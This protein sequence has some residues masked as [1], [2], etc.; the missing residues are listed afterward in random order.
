[1]LYNTQIMSSGE[2]TI[3]IWDVESRQTVLQ[4]RNQESLRGVWSLCFSPDGTKVATG[5]WVPDNYIYHVGHKD[6]RC[7]P[8]IQ[9]ALSLCAIFGIQPRRTKMS[10]C[11]SRYHPG[12]PRR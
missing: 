10:L 1:M 5:D 2:D 8:D 3:I 9:G 12:L 4:L 7:A 6:W 11:I